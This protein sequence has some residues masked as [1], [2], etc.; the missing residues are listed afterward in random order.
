MLLLPFAWLAVTTGSSTEITSRTVRLGSTRR[1][2]STC[3]NEELDFNA[4]I[5][6]A[7]E[8]DSD[9]EYDGFCRPDHLYALIKEKPDYIQRCMDIGSEYKLSKKK[10]K[11]N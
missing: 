9:D 7:N 11:L 4:D 5:L 1:L 2:G 8:K 6:D 3:I 10:R